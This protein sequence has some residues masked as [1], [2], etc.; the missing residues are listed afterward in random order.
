MD[1]IEN[2]PS[3]EA[4]GS[5]WYA[6]TMVAAPERPPLTQDID[7]DVC[8]IGGG[9]AGI[10]AAREVARR[11][12]SVAILE[13]RRLAW[14]ASGRNCGFVLPGFSQDI[15]RIVERVGLQ[16]AKELWAQ[17]EAGV[18]Y[19]RTAIR[20]TAMQGVDPVDGWLYVEKTDN[21]E[22]SIAAVRLLGQEFGVEVEGWP[23]DRVRAVLNCQHYFHAMHFP[24][25]FHI[26]PLNYALGLA[27]QAEREG[28]RIFEDTPALSIDPAGVRK[29]I[30]TPHARV[31]AGQIVL[32]GNVH[33]GRLMKRLPGTLLPIWTYLITTA[34]LGERLAEAITYRGAVSDTDLADNHYRIVGGDRLLLSG[35]ATA[36]ERDPRR[37]AGRLAGDLAR[38]YPQ[39][40]KV[41]VEHMW[42]GVLGRTVHR[43][44]QIGELAPGLWLAS[45]FSGH[46]LN[47]TAMAG[48]LIARAIVDGDTA[49][50]L[51]SPY[52]LVWT[53]GWIGRTMMQVGY[54]T[55]RIRARTDARLAR[56]RE[57]AYLREQEREALREEMEE[58]EA[59][60]AEAASA[61]RKP[62]E[63]PPAPPTASLP[64]DKTTI[65]PYHA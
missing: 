61:S 30:T 46:G 43:M 42:S 4:Y 7:V 35:R 13:T 18:E 51:F 12:W 28:A 5:S 53:G 17:S 55:H 59:A 37:Y 15:E 49:W 2:A 56:K 63:T 50:R 25:A 33:L 60:K 62:A 36:W 16:H 20:E 48:S 31:R 58:R 24:K 40:G 54:W 27:G 1:G 38:L 26:H 9:L 10:T 19:V 23:V 39:L 45:G 47:T 21:A 29:R 6:E 64:E 65:V 41:E 57:A 22:Q 14:N 8:V 3:R 52:D 32:A 11:G 44:P 34:P